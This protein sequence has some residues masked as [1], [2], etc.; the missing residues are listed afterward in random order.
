MSAMSAVTEE[1]SLITMVEN[2]KFTPDYCIFS[3][4]KS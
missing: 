3:V 2:F 1:T 4:E